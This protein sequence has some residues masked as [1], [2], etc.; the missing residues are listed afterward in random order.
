MGTSD[1]SR[2]VAFRR[3]AS[4][5]TLNDLR[6]AGSPSAA[7]RPFLVSSLRGSPECPRSEESFEEWVRRLRS[8]DTLNFVY[9]ALGELARRIERTS[10]AVGRA[11]GPLRETQIVDWTRSPHGHGAKTSAEAVVDELLF[12]EQD[13][14]RRFLD[15]AY[16]RVSRR[17]DY[18]DEDPTAL[19][20]EV[21]R[22]LKK[23]LQSHKDFA[24]EWE[25]RLFAREGVACIQSGRLRGGLL[26]TLDRVLRSR[27]AEH[28]RDVSR[29]AVVV[30]SQAHFR[31][32]S[33]ADFET[34]LEGY[35]RKS[36]LQ[37]QRVG[38]AGDQGADLIVR[39]AHGQVVI[40]AK[41][42]R[43]NVGNK[44]VQEVHAAR[45]FYRAAAAFVVT[46]AHFTKGA[47]ELAERLG[48][49]LVEGS[50]LATLASR[51]RHRA[52]RR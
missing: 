33:G 38:A 37:A 9:F 13:R 27:F 36:G 34:F 2:V 35:L 10:G 46:T 12:R 18:G 39:L 52:R 5:L 3:Y 19:N 25:A 23:L 47:R 32:M 49:D 6:S 15:I 42:V 28:R 41:N 24:P 21:E 40:Q 31:T 45:G 22:F 51:L 43:N 4:Q 29:M 1:E 14:F 11:P 17:D 7:L 50:E 48:V 20:L 44:A 30:P 16:R 26:E 8:T